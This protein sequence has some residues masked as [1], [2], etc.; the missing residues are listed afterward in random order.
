MTNN[1]DT[2]A[3]M[4]TTKHCLIFKYKQYSDIFYNNNSK[5]FGE[6]LKSMVSVTIS[7]LLISLFMT[8]GTIKARSNIPHRKSL[9]S[10]VNNIPCSSSYLRVC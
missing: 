3:S 10:N 2:V 7:Y 6:E 1:Y 5:T 4:K 8:T 9:A